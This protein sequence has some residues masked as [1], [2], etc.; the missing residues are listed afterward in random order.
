MKFKIFK[1]EK[2]TSTNDMAIELIKNKKEEIGCIYAETQTKGR[3]KYGKKWI[4]ERGN[5]FFSIFFP[6]KKNYPTFNEFSIINPVII[7]DII[8]HFCSEQEI[9]L[10]FPNDVFMNKKK[11]SGVLQEHLIFNNKNFLIIGIGINIISNPLINESYQTTN[12][13]LET[14]KK[15]EISEI[16]E[17]II[18]KYENFFLNLNSYKYTNF[19]DRAETISIN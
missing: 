1:F 10:K 14:K 16:I 12:I 2:V 19:K 3:G 6:L 15:L 7:Y 18:L 4:S 9:N 13:L 8:K 11:I 17:K 5:L